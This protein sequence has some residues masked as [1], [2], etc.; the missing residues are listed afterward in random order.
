M[1]PSPPPA[2]PADMNGNLNVIT[3]AEC[4]TSSAKYWDLQQ[5]ILD[6]WCSFEWCLCDGLN[7]QLGLFKFE[8]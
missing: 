6:L 1:A 8:C 7:F 2:A 4:L 3:S 5:W